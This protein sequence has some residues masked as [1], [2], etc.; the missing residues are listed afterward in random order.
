MRLIADNIRIVD[1][2][3]IDIVPFYSQGWHFDYPIKDLRRWTPRPVV[4]EQ[5]GSPGELGRPVTIPKHQEALM[6]EKFKLNQF[7]LLA[8][9]SI[10]FNRSLPD[11]RLD[12]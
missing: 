11:V 12:G 9:D 6:K 2:C 3:F 1:G 7:N 5:P 10:S 8:S 4:G